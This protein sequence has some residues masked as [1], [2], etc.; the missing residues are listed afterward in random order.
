[1]VN[2]IH[3]EGKLDADER[4]T[5]RRDELSTTNDALKESTHE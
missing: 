4:Y 1:M 3:L 5:L 2:G